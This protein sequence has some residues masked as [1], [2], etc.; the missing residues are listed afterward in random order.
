MNQEKEKNPKISPGQMQKVMSSAEGKEL[1]A[2]LQESG[3]LREAMEAFKKG[4]MKGVQAALGP[5]ME[6]EKATELMGKI[7][8]K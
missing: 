2:L 7:N 5:I 8:R 3:K 4:D 6:S 1:L